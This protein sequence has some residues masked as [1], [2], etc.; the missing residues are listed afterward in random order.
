MNSGGRHIFDEGDY[1]DDDDDKNTQFYHINEALHE[2]IS[3]E[4]AGNP[5]KLIKLRTE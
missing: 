3:H 1:D 5:Y 2:K 4:R